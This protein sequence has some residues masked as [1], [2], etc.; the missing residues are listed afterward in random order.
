MYV[1]LSGETEPLLWE[2]QEGKCLAGRD[3]DIDRG[4]KADTGR[5]PDGRTEAL[6]ANEE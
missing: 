2:G 1:Y 4:R 5:R 6:R 3:R